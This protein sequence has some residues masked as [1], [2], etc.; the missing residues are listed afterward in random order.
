MACIIEQGHAIPE[1][2]AGAGAPPL[3]EEAQC[4]DGSA[5]HR[6]HACVGEEDERDIAEAG[7]KKYEIMLETGV[8]GQLL[9]H[10]KSEVLNTGF[11]GVC[12]HAW[13]QGR[14]RVPS[15]AART[16]VAPPQQSGPA[17][18]RQLMT[19]WG[20]AAMCAHGRQDCF[21][22]SMFSDHVQKI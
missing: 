1:A 15:P 17:R 20:V 19:C 8:R 22:G 7:L 3:R 12:V 21:S 14:H 13:R 2:G 11:A 9:Q 10:E 6:H 16:R 4:H 18:R 5:S